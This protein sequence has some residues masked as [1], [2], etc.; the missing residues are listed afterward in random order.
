MLGEALNDELSDAIGIAMKIALGDKLEDTVIEAVT[1]WL[2]DDLSAPA[3]IE[4]TDIDV[5]GVSD[6]TRDF[7]LVGDLDSLCD[8]VTEFNA[9]PEILGA[10]LDL[11]PTMLDWVGKTIGDSEEP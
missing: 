7:E 8:A 5:E 2:G 1:V 4:L 9:L 11:K 3:I 6:A 10:M